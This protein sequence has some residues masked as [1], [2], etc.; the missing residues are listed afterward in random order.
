VAC[1]LNIVMGRSFW[2]VGGLNPAG[3][4]LHR[5]PVDRLMLK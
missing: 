4:N 3:G 5:K 2:A 1:K